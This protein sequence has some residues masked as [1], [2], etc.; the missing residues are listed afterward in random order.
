VLKEIRKVHPE[1]ELRFW[2]DRGFYKQASATVAR[3]D[4]TIPVQRIIAGK[5]RRYNHLSFF[6]QM[7]VPGLVVKNI[8]DIFLVGVGT[9]QSFFKLIFWRPDVVFTKGGFVCLPVGLAAH[10]LRIPLVIH[11]SDAHP[12]LTNR[13]LAR[14][15][16]QIATGAP[17][18]YYPYPK[19]RT[20]YIGIPVASELAPVDDQ[21]IHAAKEKWGVPTDKPLVVVT[22]GGLGA[23]RINDTIVALR[24]KLQGLTSVILVAGA[25]QYDELKAKLPENNADFQLYAFV[26]EMPSLLTAADVVVARAGATTILELAALEKPTILIPNVKLTGGHQVKNAK[27]YSDAQA[28]TIVNEDE[29]LAQPDLLLAAITTLL[30]DKKAARDMAARFHAFARPNAARDMAALII[31]AI[32]AK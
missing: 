8:R 30:S 27:V 31:S 28:V 5:L 24:A 6:Q 15:A 11:D 23:T 4:E 17:L 22:G 21:A 18:E 7:T 9:L 14:W 2:C 29:M 20:H 16:N 3:F 32:R 10:W 1:A 25:G 26:T 19:S 13:I 12:G